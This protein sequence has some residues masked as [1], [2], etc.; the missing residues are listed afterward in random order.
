MPA[1]DRL[2][3]RRAGDALERHAPFGAAAARVDDDELRL[4]LD[5]VGRGAHADRERLAGDGVDG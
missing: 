5:E 4:D 1:V 2:A 3:A